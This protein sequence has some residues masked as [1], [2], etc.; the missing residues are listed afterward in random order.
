MSELLRLRERLKKLEE[1]LRPYQ[2]SAEPVDSE[3]LLA[4]LENGKRVEVDKKTRTEVINFFT[5]LESRANAYIREQRERGIPEPPPLT[6]EERKRK[7]T[8]FINT[9]KKG[10]VKTK[11]DSEEG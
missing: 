1:K 3:L 5:S 10:M 2:H 9:L 4:E 11:E 6:D 7:L 8:D